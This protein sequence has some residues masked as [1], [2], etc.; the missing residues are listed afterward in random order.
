MDAFD[1]KSAYNTLY[2]WLE[3]MSR[4]I[5]SLLSL[6]SEHIFPKRINY[7]LRRVVY[8]LFNI[9]TTNLI[10]CVIILTQL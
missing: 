3:V 10:I 9:F 6:I 2:T 4:A 1:S 5:S 7:I 8:Y